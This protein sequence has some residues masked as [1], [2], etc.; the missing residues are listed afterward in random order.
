VLQQC[1][2][3]AVL[4]LQHCVNVDCVSWVM[5][6]CAQKCM[7]WV[8]I[9]K[10]VGKV[11]VGI[12]K[13]RGLTHFISKKPHDGPCL[14]KVK[15]RTCCSFGGADCME[16]FSVSCVKEL[17]PQHAHNVQV[18]QDITLSHKQNEPMNK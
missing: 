4:K 14:L 17:I 16:T 12:N 15:V 13:L 10:L 1:C 7:P 11:D 6:L 2:D 3:A 8:Q 18:L 5:A 9:M